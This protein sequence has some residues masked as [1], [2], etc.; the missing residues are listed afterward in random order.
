MGDFGSK[1]SKIRPSKDC[2]HDTSNRNK[3]NRQQ[4]NND[5][6]NHAVDDINLQEKKASAESESHE[7]IESEIDGKNLYHID[8]MSLDKKK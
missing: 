3:F 2:G 8:N 7:N 5:I 6:V 4:D 1:Y